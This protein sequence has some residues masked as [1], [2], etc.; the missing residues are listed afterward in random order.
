MWILFQIIYLFF[1]LLFIIIFFFNF[2]QQIWFSQIKS[3]FLPFSK[4]G[5][6]FTNQV[7]FFNSTNN[8]YDFLLF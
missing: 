5:L 6:I 2:Q 7:S 1:Y 4:T 3:H 8:K